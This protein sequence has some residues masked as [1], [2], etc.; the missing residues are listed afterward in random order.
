MEKSWEGD[1]NSMSCL[2]VV[3]ENEC[4][5]LTEALEV[6]ITHSVLAPE[7]HEVP[8]M[9]NAYGLWQLPLP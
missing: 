4:N 1:T 9:L 8:E 2:H 5:E 7:V 6:H 3:L